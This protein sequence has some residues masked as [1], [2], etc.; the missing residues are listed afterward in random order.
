MDDNRYSR[1]LVK[2]LALRKGFFCWSLIRID[3][4]FYGLLFGAHAD[5]GDFCLIRIDTDLFLSTRIQGI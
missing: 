4:D 5:L 2:A 3:T 1:Y